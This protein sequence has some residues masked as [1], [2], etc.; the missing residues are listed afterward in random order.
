MTLTR[1]IDRHARPHAAAMLA[2]LL[3]AAP[4][5]RAQT[6]ADVD[7]DDDDIG[8]VVMSRNGPEAG[9][10]VIA[11]TSARHTRFA[12]IVVT[13]DQGR[14]VVPDLPDAA[15][16]VWVR[17]YGLVDSQRVAT[18]PGEQ[19]ALTVTPA[20]DPAVAAETYPAIYWYSMMRLP[21]EDEAA[22]IP[23]GLSRYIASMTNLGCIGCHQ[24]GQRSTRTIPASLGEFGS[25]IDAWVRRLQSGQAGDA[26][27]AIAAGQLGGT[28][29][30][31][32][33]DWTD[34]IAAGE[35]P[36]ARP[37]RPRGIERNVVVT[38]RDWS[39][40]KAYMHDLSSTDRRNPTVNGYGKIYGAPE[41][42]TDEFPI[43]DPVADTATSFHAPVR[44]RDTPST[45]DTPPLQPSP[46]WDDES[47]WNSR[48]NAH[49]SMLD[50]LGRVWYTARIRAPGNP[51]FCR[52]G[53]DHP[54][55]K[56]FPLERSSRHLAL[57]EPESG[58]YTFIDTCFS[59]HHLQF[60]A[61]ER[62]TLWT[63]GGGEVVGWLD[64]KAF[65]ETGDAA[66]AQ[67]WTA[68]VLDTNG[69]GRR[70]DYVEPDEP[71][72]PTKDKRIVAGFYAVMPSPSD[73]AIW[74]S[75]LGF[76]GAVVRLDPG[77]SPPATALAEIYRVPLPGFGAR[78]ADIDSEGV[79]W[80]SLGS[81]HL[82]AFDRRKC[83]GPLNGP[84]ATGD[85]CRE[86]W[87]FYRFPGPGF[88]GRPEA[89]AEASYYTW[90]DQH[91]TLGLGRD[92]PMA[93][94]NL[95]DGIHALVDG[96]FVT[97]RVPYPLGFY[98]K[99]FDG[100]IDD[101]DAGWKGRGLWVPSG[102]R[103][104]WLMEGGKGTKPLVAHIQLRPH[105]LAK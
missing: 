71:L 18:R 80:V 104:P 1:R 79:V 84:E 68:L 96:E 48:A 12:R 57:Y 13:D 90:V 93:T 83:E 22:A 23:G 4:S 36:R 5:P 9:V 55:A 19:V 47:I 11:E 56:L 87:S 54:S 88:E 78:G 14:F 67:G 32:L 24:L 41:L 63:S 21:S 89:S 74:G 34:R 91:D 38:I 45:A 20:T 35:L 3:A 53:S 62:N 27:I 46:Y 8:G 58:D 76:P 44:D 92:V 49:N 85:H 26:M 25:S 42:S 98:T 65:D 39:T 94:A 72:D 70:D 100:R 51:A 50:H 28:P 17:G 52:R 99:G 77:P 64:T 95:F 66:R 40:E 97:L 31:Y 103:T 60:A 73:G 75:S 30:R 82:G 7:I 2:A 81:G 69:N 61:D 29:L 59:T 16:S 15:Y 86:G 37:S 33:A 6:S 105:P 43:L 101:P 10:W 102:D